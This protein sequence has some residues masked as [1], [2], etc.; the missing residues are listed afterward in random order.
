[1]NSLLTIAIDAAKEAGAEIKR[2]YATS[3]WTEK[4]DGSPVTIA[5]M[6]SHEIV[7]AS[8]IKTD[9]PVLSEESEDT[10]ISYASNLW[11]VDPLDGTQGFIKKSDAFSVMIALLHDGVPILGVVY[12][13]IQDDLY[14]AEHG[15]GAFLVRG[16]LT[17]KLVVRNREQDDL[18]FVRSVNNATPEMRIV[19]EQ[20]GATFRPQGSLGMKIGIIAEGVGDF[21]Y[22]RGNVG[23]WDVAAPQVILE[24]AGGTM[25]DCEGN[26]IHYGN[27]DHRLTNGVLSSNGA[28]HKRVLDVLIKEKTA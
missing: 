10:E 18:I 9:I 4:S 5:D 23:E 27:S 25:T 21:S 26:P 28:C 6:R 17:T 1:M 7:Y 14:Y 12:A 22:T 15:R 24:E 13:P 2:L 20:L 16:G 3:D 11:I 19:A 8:L